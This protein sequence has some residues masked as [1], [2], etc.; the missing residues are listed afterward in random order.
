LIAHRILHSHAGQSCARSTYLLR[1]TGSENQLRAK[2]L[3]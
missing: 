2:R 3:H 1:H